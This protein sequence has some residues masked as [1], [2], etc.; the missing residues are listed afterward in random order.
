M[1]RM[2]SSYQETICG[3][4]VSSAFCA[5]VRRAATT[6]WVWYSPGRSAASARCQMATPSVISSVPVSAVLVGQLPGEPNGFGG[7]VEV[8]R[9]ALRSS[10]NSPKVSS[11]GR[12]MPARR[13]PPRKSLGRRCTPAN[14]S[15]QVRWNWIVSFH[16]LTGNADRIHHFV[17]T[18]RVAGM[19]YFVAHLNQ[20]THDIIGSL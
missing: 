9:V 1:G 18:R 11:F 12:I 3:R 16:D 5:S 4:S 6:D 15:L 2:S 17:V 8:A 13:L 7:Q 20:T 19:S 14:C 10:N